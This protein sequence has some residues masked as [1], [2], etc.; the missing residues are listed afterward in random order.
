MTLRNLY[1]KHHWQA[2]GR[3]LYQL[4][5]LFDKQAPGQISSLLAFIVAAYAFLTVI[6]GKDE[7]LALQS[8]TYVTSR[9]VP[10]AGL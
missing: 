8:E 9:S 2:A 4:Q 7:R 3:T 1:K 5:L 6:A 10:A